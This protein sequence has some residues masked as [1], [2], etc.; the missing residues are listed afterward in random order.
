MHK[1]PHSYR[2]A[3]RHC[4]LTLHCMAAV[5]VTCAANLK[6]HPGSNVMHVPEEQNA[7]E[8]SSVRLQRQPRLP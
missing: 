4:C 2:T 6:T 3:H 8:G 7:A 1:E 5:S